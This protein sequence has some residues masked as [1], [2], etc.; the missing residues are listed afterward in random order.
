MQILQRVLIVVWIAALIVA[1]TLGHYGYGRWAE[2][3]AI[4]VAVTAFAWQRW[5]RRRML[6]KEEPQ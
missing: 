3:I 6:Q 4:T 2:W 1:V 5:T